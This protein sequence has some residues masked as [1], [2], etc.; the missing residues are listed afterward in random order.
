VKKAA[1]EAAAKDAPS[2]ATEAAEEKK[3]GPP[4]PAEKETGET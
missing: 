2:P 1:A 4:S 3:D